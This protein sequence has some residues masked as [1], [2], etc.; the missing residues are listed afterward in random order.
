MQGVTISWTWCEASESQVSIAKSYGIH[1]RQI[2]RIVQTEAADSWRL[3]IQPTPTQLEKVKELAK[4]RMLQL[5]FYV[6]FQLWSHRFSQV[7][8]RQM[9]VSGAFLLQKAK[10]LAS[11]HQQADW[12]TGRTGTAK[13]K[14]L[15]GE[16]QDADD[17]SAERCTTDVLPG[18]I[19]DYAT[20]RWNHTVLGAIADIQDCRDNWQQGAKRK[21][22]TAV[23]LQH[24]CQREAWATWWLEK[25]KCHAASKMSRNCQWCI[26]QQKCL[27]DWHLHRMAE[28]TWLENES[29]ETSDSYAV[30]QLLCSQQW[31]S[32]ESTE[33]SDSYAARQLLAVMFKWEHRDVR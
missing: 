14:R 22:T 2:S 30:S 7:W 33:T 11:S 5:L 18:I 1:P 9:P 27:D 29:I 10:S 4:Q 24:G 20:C 15:H 19:K 13:F 16:K 3:A 17:F 8:S 21:S 26:S 6:G 31:C 25:A 32:N 12:N 23:G 28:E